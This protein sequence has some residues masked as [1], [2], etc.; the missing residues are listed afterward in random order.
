MSTNEKILKVNTM[1]YGWMFF[2]L[3]VSGCTVSLALNS[4][5]VA[6]TAVRFSN[7]DTD[8]ASPFDPFG[9]S[10]GNVQMR[11]SF[12]TG[13]LPAGHPTLQP[14]SRIET[15]GSHLLSL[16][17]PAG[18]IGIVDLYGDSNVALSDG[19]VFGV[20]VFEN[21]VLNV[22]NG[23]VMGLN[24]TSGR[25]IQSGGQLDLGVASYNARGFGLDPNPISSTARFLISGGTLSGNELTIA[26]GGVFDMVGGF[27]N[28]SLT[29]LGD[30]TFEGGSPSPF[31]SVSGATASARFLG[32]DFRF[33][34]NEDDLLNR[35][36]DPASYSNITG[37]SLS[38]SF[39]DSDPAAFGFI[40]G[41][42]SDGTDFGLS[43]V[44][45]TNGAQISFLSDAPITE[46]SG[47][48]LEGT[49][50]GGSGFVGGLDV[51]FNNIAM[52]G[53]FSSEYLQTAAN[54]LEQNFLVRYAGQGALTFE[55][56]S[57]QVQH[58]DLDFDGEFNGP[59]QLT[60]GYDD[61]DL[62][63]VEENLAIY[64]FDE[65]QFRWERLQI[66]NRDPAGNTIT[67]VA[68]NFSPFVLGV[69]SSVPEPGSSSLLLAISLISTV[70]RRRRNQFLILLTPK[71]QP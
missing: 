13:Q 18:N 30:A 5:L 58:W 10:G 41:R 37:S 53:T 33:Y 56:A 20:N 16:N 7:L 64:H 11:S 35:P 27:L 67:V 62:A 61:A 48:D 45:L 9:G 1:R 31:L 42:L 59:V 29:V 40:T 66:L 68:T 22:S 49:V 25:V 51:A 55:P 38:L 4:T 50:E 47:V 8:S 46:L 15:Y 6:Q 24:P 28:T 36:D 17:N 14:N 70:A 60:F 26:P 63:T 2:G 57:Q 54:D 23:N 21:G 34:Q 71:T 32:S 65:Q 12:Q 39:S 19:S 43:S 69:V 44:S 3:L 52:P